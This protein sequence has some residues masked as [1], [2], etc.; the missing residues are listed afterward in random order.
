MKTIFKAIFIATFEGR[1]SFLIAPLVR[2]VSL[3]KAARAR[4]FIPVDIG[5]LLL[6]T[7]WE[8]VW[9][10]SMNKICNCGFM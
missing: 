8:N 10:F 9:A 4:I 2:C 6:K 1:D 3:Q 5:R 7:Q